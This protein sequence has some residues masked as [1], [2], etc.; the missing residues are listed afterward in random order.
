[1]M[2]GAWPPPA[3]SEWIRVDRA[4]LER[5][6][7][8]LDESGFIQCIGVDGD[9]NV[10]LIGHPKAGVNGGRSRSPVFV[11]LQS[12]CPCANLFPQRLR[13]RTI[14]LAKKTEI[15]RILLRSLQHPM[16]IPMA[17]RARRG[18]GAVAGPVPPPIIVVIPLAIACSIC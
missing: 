9:L 17:G 18:I 12:D 16:N 3:P 4:P 13:S 1:M 14:A 7:R 8:V 10:E 2:S 5:A 15:H 11:K 6:Q